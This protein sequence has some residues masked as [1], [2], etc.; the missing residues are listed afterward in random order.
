MKKLVTLLSLFLLTST[1]FAFTDIEN[2]PFEKGI[3][4]LKDKGIIQGDE[5]T[6]N[7]RP[8]S[9]INRAE[10]TKIVVMSSNPENLDDYTDSCF[11]D[12]PAGQWYT[13]V[14]CYAKDQGWVKGYADGNFRP[15]QNVTNFEG[16]KIAAISQEIK[17]TESEGEFWYKTLVETLASNNLIPFTVSKPHA[18]LTRAEMADLI[19]RIY[20][21]QQGTLLD[22]LGDK[23]GLQ[24]TYDSI[25][26]EEDLSEYRM[27]QLEG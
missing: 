6:S 10:I 26:A 7:F 12:V 16:M 2:S 4:E 11:N 22:Y 25:H 5:G 8:E 17:F 27:I 24:A 20:H 3:L 19:S 9:G 1:A 15:A 13:S 18:N 23:S 21:N 14:V